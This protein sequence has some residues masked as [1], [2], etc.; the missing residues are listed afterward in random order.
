[1]LFQIEEFEVETKN[2]P[3]PKSGTT[4]IWKYGQPFDRPSKSV[5]AAPKKKVNV[6][7]A[8]ARGKENAKPA[9][10]DGRFMSIMTLTP[11]M[12]KWVIKG[13]NFDR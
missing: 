8:P 1:M 2:F 13:N 7:G 9:T 3:L 6:P 11:Y 4:Q 12:N 5:V 10:A